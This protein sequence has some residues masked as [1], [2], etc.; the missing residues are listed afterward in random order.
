MQSGE[1]GRT[2]LFRSIHIDPYEAVDVHRI[3]DGAGA[4][5]KKGV[6]GRPGLGAGRYG[7]QGTCL[8]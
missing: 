1:L 8:P 4:E 3:A 2:D 5:D 7:E 6:G